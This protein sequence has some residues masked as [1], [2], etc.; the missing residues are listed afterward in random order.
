MDG[1]DDIGDD[2]E[3]AVVF[4]WG[5]PS[6]DTSVGANHQGAEGSAYQALQ[7]SC[8]EGAE[9]LSPDFA[10]EYGFESPRN[11]LLFAAGVQLCEGDRAAAAAL[12]EPARAMGVEGLAPETWAFC[13]LYR[14]VGS[15]LEQRP[16]EE[17]ACAGG[18]APPFKVGD[19][20]TIDDPLTLD[21]DESAAEAESDLDGETE[22]GTGTEPEPGTSTE[23]AP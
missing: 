12:F 3:E 20:G 13:V 7:V 17:F 15:V 8:S 19:N 23:P 9:F 18:S 10:P 22:T 6:S 2:D 16:P 11:V 21:A 4:E 5:L 14:T 1:S